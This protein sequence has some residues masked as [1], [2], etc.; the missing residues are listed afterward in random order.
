MGAAVTDG[1]AMFAWFCVLLGV[2]AAT[3]LALGIRRGDG[4]TNRGAV[5]A[6]HVGVTLGALFYFASAGMLALQLW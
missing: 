4:S 6:L 1:R 2:A 3:C 5:R